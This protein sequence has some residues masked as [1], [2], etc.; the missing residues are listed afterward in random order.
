MRSA[1]ATTD[2]VEVGGRLVEAQDARLYREDGGYRQALLLAA[3][4]GGWLSVLEAF[5][6]YLFER[7]PDAADHLC[8]LD[9]EVLRAEG[10]FEGDVGGE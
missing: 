10:G 8:V 2:G 3:G 1:P 4:E 5:E 9:V 6:A 7:F